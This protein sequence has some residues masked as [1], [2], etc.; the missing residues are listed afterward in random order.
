V[1]NESNALDV[2]EN[3]MV[4]AMI[5]DMETLGLDGAQLIKLVKVARLGER[6]LPVIA[7]TIDGDGPSSRQLEELGLDAILTKPV[8][9]KTLLSTLTMVLETQ[10][11]SP[12]N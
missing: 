2:L 10:A 6:P 3:S 7:L 12:G 1:S 11:S 8:P 9:P 5:V 4:D